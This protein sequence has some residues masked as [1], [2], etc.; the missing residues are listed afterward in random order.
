MKYRLFPNTDIRVSEVG[1]GTWTVSTG[2]W[3]EKTDAEAASMMR[4]ALDE[5]GITFFD[6]ADAY[7][8]GRAERQVAEAFRGRREEVVIGTKIGNYN[9]DA[10]FGATSANLNTLGAATLSKAT[11]EH[12]YTLFV[13]QTQLFGFSLAAAGAVGGTAQMTISNS[14]GNV[15]FSLLAPTGDTTTAMSTLLP[16]GEYTVRVTPI[17]P[18]IGGFEPVS[19]TIVGSGLSCPHKT[20]S[21]QRAASR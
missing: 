5:H 16:P 8:N 1:F 6:A 13:G 15:V 19:Y 21:R 2:W 9:L 14:L 12:Q 3:G 7:G 10:T 4:R 17:A 20:R 11:S 18:T